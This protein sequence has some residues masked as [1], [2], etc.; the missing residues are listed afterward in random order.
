MD[1]IKYVNTKKFYCGGVG[2][3]PGKALSAWLHAGGDE[4]YEWPQFNGKNVILTHKGRVA[5][6][7]AL[8][9]MNI[10]PGDEVLVPAYNCGSEV[11]AILSTGVKVVF[12]RVNEK[13]RIDPE[14]IKSRLTSKTRVLY[15]THY[16]GWSHNLGELVDWCKEQNLFLIEDCALSLFSNGSGCPI[17]QIGDAA[18]YSFPK[19]LPVPEGGALVL[20]EG[21]EKMEEALRYPEWQG[22]YP[23]MLPLLKRW[24]IRSGEKKKDFGLSQKLLSKSFMAHSHK[25]EQ[26][27]RPEMPSD[28]YFEKRIIDRSISRISKGIL[29]QLDYIEIIRIRRRNYAQLFKAV[30]DLRGIQPLYY[31]LPE[32]VCP[33][34]LPVLVSDRQRLLSALNEKGILTARWWA[35]YHRSLSWENFPEACE[36]KDRLLT[37]PVHQDLDEDHVDYI[38]DCVKSLSHRK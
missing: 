30:C 8:Q 6:V 21:N 31:D 22:V 29:N 36:L 34:W 20:P 37:L 28:Y 26:P 16:F 33:L 7:L 32:G 18:I 12:Y 9:I 15:V 25:D 2:F 17:G 5:I 3:S 23:K 14:D 10:S 1:S 27:V 35:G 24:L 4:V 13:A 11:D 19:T 38:A